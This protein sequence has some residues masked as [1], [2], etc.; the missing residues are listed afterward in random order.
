[1]RHFKSTKSSEVEATSIATTMP[2]RYCN[3]CHLSTPTANPRCIHCRCVLTTDVL[4][5]HI[6]RRVA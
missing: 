6:E 3:R 2:R 5:N 1:M 4:R